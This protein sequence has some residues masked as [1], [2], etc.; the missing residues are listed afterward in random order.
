MNMYDGIVARPGVVSDGTVRW[1]DDDQTGESVVVGEIP[2]DGACSGTLNVGSSYV[3][4]DGST[5]GGALNLIPENCSAYV[6][7]MFT[8]D[9]K[10]PSHPRIILAAGDLREWAEGPLPQDAYDSRVRMSYTDSTSNARTCYIDKEAQVSIIV[11]HA[12]GFPAEMPDFV[13]DDFKRT[14]R[15]EFDSL[16]PEPGASYGEPCFRAMAVAGELMV[17][18]EAANFTYQEECCM[19]DCH[20]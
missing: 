15:V 1:T 2:G 9:C 3:S 18:I 5:G 8:I 12:E 7:V 10:L 16:E 20:N 17:E 6:N 11:D 13:T 4:E 14:I 19:A